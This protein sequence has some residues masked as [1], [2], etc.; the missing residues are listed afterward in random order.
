MPIAGTRNE[1]GMRWRTEDGDNLAD[2]GISSQAR[3]LASCV[4]GSIFRKQHG[5]LGGENRERVLI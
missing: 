2:T 3:M 1:N 4:E 5:G